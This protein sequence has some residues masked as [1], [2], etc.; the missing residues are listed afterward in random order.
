MEIIGVGIDAVEVQRLRN[1]TD[2]FFGKVFTEEER[3]YCRTQADPYPSFAAR[4]AAKEAAIKALRDR[5]LAYRD[6][7]V[8]NE[9]NGAPTLQTPI[10]GVACHMSI[11]HTRDL[12][13]SIVIITRS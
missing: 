12:A 9:Q 2:A 10:Q 13:I 1:A 3:A 8:S 7:S 5:P 11:S 4:F 6:I